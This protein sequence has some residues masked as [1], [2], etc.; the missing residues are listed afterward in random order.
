MSWTEQLI[1]SVE[2]F[3]R[4]HGSLLEV[5][6]RCSDLDMAR[7]AYAMGTLAAG[8]AGLGCVTPRWVR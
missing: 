5:L 3:D 1:Y 7:A 4:P 6:A 8:A 2:V